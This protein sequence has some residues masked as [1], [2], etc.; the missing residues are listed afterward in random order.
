MVK[1]CYYTTPVKNYAK[2]VLP[3]KAFTIPI[4]LTTY[5]GRRYVPI[6]NIDKLS[7]LTY[8]ASSD[9]VKVSII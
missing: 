1:P 4:F 9:C 2:S 3:N 6:N 8:T 5:C 7:D